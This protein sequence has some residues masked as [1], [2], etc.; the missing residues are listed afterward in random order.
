MSRIKLLGLTML[1]AAVLLVSCKGN[2]GNE[3]SDNS[4]TLD[5]Y[6]YDNYENVTTIGD[7]AP[8]YDSTSLVSEPIMTED[9]QGNLSPET[10]VVENDADVFYVIAG[11]FTVYSNAQNLCNKLKTKG[12]PS[13][14]L[15]P[16]GQYNRVAVKSFKTRAE[17]KASLAS[18]K[19]RLNDEGLWILKR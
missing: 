12:F 9:Q 17:A 1:S 11:S 6:P 16:F 13:E 5:T 3:S 8:Q 14:I 2:K 10:N 18:L 15:I 4:D 7:Q 19:S